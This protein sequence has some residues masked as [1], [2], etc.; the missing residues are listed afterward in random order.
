[1]IKILLIFDEAQE[2]NITRT[3]LQKSGFDCDGMTTELG[4]AEKILLM[5][6]DLICISV[7]GIRMNENSLITKLRQA[8]KFNGKIIFVKKH[9]EQEGN[10]ETEKLVD[11]IIAYPPEPL[12][13]IEQICI[14]HQEKSHQYLEK[15]L[16]S[17]L[18]NQASE[19]EI[20]GAKN[21]LAPVSYAALK[22]LFKSPSDPKEKQK[23]DKRN[24]DFLKDPLKKEFVV[25]STSTFKRDNVKSMWQ[26]MTKDWSVAELEQ[27]NIL[28]MQF[29]KALLKKRG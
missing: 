4:L 29:A 15:Y 8:M 27:Q 18:P 24:Q 5:R 11:A 6:P 22:S 20:A 28:K 12:L 26:A 23:R 13:F 9:A 16:R 2:M 3:Y 7:N 1:M 14:L 19:V 10:L 17:Y 25:K 21:E